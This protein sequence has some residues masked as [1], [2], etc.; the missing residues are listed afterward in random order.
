MDTVTYMRHA[1]QLVAGIGYGTTAH[2]NGLVHMAHHSL[3]RTP[4]Q[5]QVENG[6]FQSPLQRGA[7]S[8]EGAVT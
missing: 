4:L 5:K 3:I 7:S 1:H 6:G 8:F 2:A